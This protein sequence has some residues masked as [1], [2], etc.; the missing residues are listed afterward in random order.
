MSSLKV[1]LKV[2]T[3]SFQVFIFS[4]LVL[5]FVVIAGIRKNCE[6]KEEPGTLFTC[7]VDSMDV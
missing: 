1:K 3:I 6:L 2:I 7:E 4:L 5:F